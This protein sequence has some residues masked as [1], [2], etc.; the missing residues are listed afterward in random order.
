MRADEP[1]ATTVPPSSTNTFNGGTDLVT[2]SEP[3]IECTSSGTVLAGGLYCIA[4]VPDIAVPALAVRNFF[5]R[6]A[7][8]C[9]ASAEEGALGEKNTSKLFFRQ[10]AATSRGE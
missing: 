4:P 5:I 1:T 6:T 8:I 2:E 7:G 10:P 3:S 9:P